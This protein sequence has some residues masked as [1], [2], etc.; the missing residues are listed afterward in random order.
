MLC[1]Y[2][3]GGQQFNV[4]LN[5]ATIQSD[6]LNSTQY[7]II[8]G[9]GGSP[10]APIALTMTMNDCNIGTSSAHTLG[11]IR[12]NAD[13]NQVLDLV[14]NNCNFGSSIEVSQPSFMSDGS[15]VAIQRA[16]K[17][18]G[19]HRTYYTFG[20][21]TLDSTIFRSGTRSTRMTPTS[22]TFSQK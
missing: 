18:N 9:L 15:R 19:A 8:I 1:G 21:L 20:L 16:N 11:D 12:F 13:V 5:N 4:V 14:C 17:V 7:G 2:N 10:T 22:A 6:S 3:V